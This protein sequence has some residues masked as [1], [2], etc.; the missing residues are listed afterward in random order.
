MTVKGLASAETI[1]YLLSHIENSHKDE[2]VPENDL[3]AYIASASDTMSRE[4]DRIRKRALADPG[5]AGDQ[6][7]ENWAELLRGWLPS[8]FH[9]VT[10]GQVLGH[11]GRTSPQV[12]VIVLS[13]FYPKALLGKKQY[14]AGGVLAAFE[15]KTTLE[16]KHIGDA[17]DTAWRVRELVPEREGTPYKELHSPVV[18]G[19][20][21]HSHSWTRPKSRPLVNIEKK[22]L[23]SDKA[24]PG[25]PRAMLDVVCVAD[26]ATWTGARFSA[27][28]SMQR[29]EIAL[30]VGTGYLVHHAG[31]VEHEGVTMEQSEGFTPIGT[32]LTDLLQ[33]LAWEHVGMRQLAQYFVVSG[34]QGSGHGTIRE[35]PMDLYSGEVRSRIRRMVETDQWP[36][37]SERWSE[38][39]P[40]FP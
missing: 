8:Y 10:K 27:R 35:R 15:C 38:W 24:S 29:G 13:P 32:A 25:N 6:G 1:D 21:A 12:D 40:A 30:N 5:T 20:L 3:Y 9:V 16:A 18:Y 31:D 28:V 34:I 23:D 33:R 36:G 22:L 19:L 26:L 11:D 2:D 4:Y 7:E 17:V 39:R 14:L 37:K